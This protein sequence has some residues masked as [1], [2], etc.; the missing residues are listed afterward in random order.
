MFAVEDQNDY[1]ESNSRISSINDISSK[2]NGY[3][4]KQG[5]QPSSN[6]SQRKKDNTDRKDGRLGNEKYKKNKEE[7]SINIEICLNIKI[8]PFN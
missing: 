8:I 4:D 6:V 1:G 7:D 3:S 2:E 5:K